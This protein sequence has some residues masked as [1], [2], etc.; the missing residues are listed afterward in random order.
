MAENLVR[1]ETFGRQ[2]F[3]KYWT[4]LTIISGFRSPELNRA[5]G[6]AIDSRHMR[7][8]AEAADLRVGGGIPGVDSGEFWA[9]LGGFWKLRGLR[10]GG[11]FKWSGS[12]LPNPKEWNH[13]D[14]G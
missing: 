12:P 6:G 5:S 11:D 3:G 2:Q 14:T 7:C 8:P 13:F 4:P 1:L 9:I 10:W